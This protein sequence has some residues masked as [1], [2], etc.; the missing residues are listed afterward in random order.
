MIDSSVTTNSPHKG[1][2]WTGSPTWRGGNGTRQR[3]PA[4]I[5]GVANR[6]DAHVGSRETD[7]SRKEIDLPQD[8]LMVVGWDRPLQSFYAQVFAP[9]TRSVCTD[10]SCWE[11]EQHIRR[12][13]QDDL[14]EPWVGCLPGE[15]PTL[16]DLERALGEHASALD[17]STKAELRQAK[18]RNE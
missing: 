2:S 18:E 6:G 9:G 11:T 1:R 3:I 16:E 17:D 12:E 4:K 10:E 14:I 15:L 5:S 7:M 8:A 13:C